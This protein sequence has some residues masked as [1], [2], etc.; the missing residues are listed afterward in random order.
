[1][2]AGCGGGK[3][4]ADKTATAVA[5]SGAATATKAP[6]TS[7]AAATKPAPTNT[8]AATASTVKIGEVASIGSVLTN[9]GGFTLYIFKDD[10]PNSGQS[11]VPAA[12][13]PNWPPLTVT[14]DAVAPPGLSGQLGTFTRP[15]GSKQVMYNGMPL[16]TFVG[17]TQP[18]QANGQGLLNLWF[19]ATPS[20]APQSTATPTTGGGGY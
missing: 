2:A 9:P 10:V 16:Y 7:T 5:K 3:S 18:G 12:I 8:P 11:S 1:L 14:G 13:A 17:D 4:S 20:P 19:A 15:D 6:A